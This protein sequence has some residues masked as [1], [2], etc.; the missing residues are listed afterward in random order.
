MED[1]KKLLGAWF[2]RFLTPYEKIT[3]IKSLALSKLSHLALVIPTINAKMIKQVETIFFN[4]IWDNKPDKV[5]RD[6]TKLPEK[7]GGLSMT[8]VK[9]FWTSFKF[10]WFRRILNSGSIL[11]KILEQSIL[12]TRQTNTNLINTLQLGPEKLKLI[13]KS[14]T[15]NFWKEVL[16]SAFPVIECEIFQTP[17]KILLSPFFDNNIITRNNKIINATSHPIIQCCHNSSRFFQ[18]W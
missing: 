7:I 10:S 6:D 2:H 4:F 16:L 18:I 5:R 14:L 13:S 3:V 12:E 9:A 8:D 1:I 11:P 15:N 17:Q